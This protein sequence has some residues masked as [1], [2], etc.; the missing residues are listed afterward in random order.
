MRCEICGNEAELQERD[1]LLICR[2]C[3]EGKMVLPS[4]PLRL[5]LGRFGAFLWGPGR[6]KKRFFDF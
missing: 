3:L 1:G 4:V 6:R 5:R 2:E